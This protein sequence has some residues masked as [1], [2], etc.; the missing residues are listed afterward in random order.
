MFPQ[1]ALAIGRGRQI[2]KEGWVRQ[3]KQA[4]AAKNNS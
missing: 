3:K 1:D 4:Q 2:V